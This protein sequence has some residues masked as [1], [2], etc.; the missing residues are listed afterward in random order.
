M[1]LIA[2]SWHI[3]RPPNSDTIITIV[4]S[5]EAA[6]SAPCSFGRWKRRHRNQKSADMPPGEG[7]KFQGAARTVAVTG[8]NKDTA[9]CGKEAYYGERRP[10]NR[11][12][13]LCTPQRQGCLAGGQAMRGMWLH[14]SLLSP[15]QPPPPH[16]SRQRAQALVRAPPSL[17]RRQWHVDIAL[18]RH[19][20]TLEFGA[21]SSG[22]RRRL[23]GLPGG[24]GVHRLCAIGQLQLAFAPAHSTP[25]E[26][27]FMRQDTHCHKVRKQQWIKCMTGQRHSHN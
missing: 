26:A 16:I 5:F 21:T 13:V 2:L 7:M 20:A 10:P 17:L 14:I 11:H 27:G 8:S 9:H 25:V 19:L 6:R 24:V 3:F 22:L 4:G 1:K 18:Q 23:R 12:L 15:P